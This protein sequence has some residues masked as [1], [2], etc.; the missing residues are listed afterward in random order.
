M[1]G[2]MRNIVGLYKRRDPKKLK[3]LH[4]RILGFSISYNVTTVKIHA[5][6]P[7]IKVDPS[8]DER[9]KVTYHS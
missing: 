8:D 4:R 9:L 7:R 1:A 5:H 6:Y 3:G 2:A